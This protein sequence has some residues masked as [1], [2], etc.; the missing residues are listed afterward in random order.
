MRLFAVRFTG[1]LAPREH[2]LGNR[3]TMQDST[4]TTTYAFD[5]HSRMTGKT[6]PGS[7]VQTNVFDA[8]ATVSR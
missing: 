8:V 5:A 4:G 6:D 7:L 2:A 1:P 3:T